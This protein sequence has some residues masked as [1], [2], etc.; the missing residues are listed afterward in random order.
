M[1]GFV[2]GTPCWVDA[3]LPDVAAGKRFYAELF[4]WTFTD[5]GGEPLPGG[6]TRGRRA[7]AYRDGSLVAALTPKRDGRMPTVWSVYL[8]TPDAAALARLITASGGQVINQPFPVGTEGTAAVV[9]DPGGAVFGLWQAGDRAGF[10]TQDEPG[11]YCWA[12]VYT[13]ARERV[14]AFYEGVFGFRGTDLGEGLG[15]EDFRMWSPPGTEPGESTA[16]GGR[17]VIDDS[18]PAEMPGH[19]LVYFR[20]AD[21][22]A[23]AATVLRLGGRVRTEP[24]DIPY[25]RTA[26]LCDDQGATFAVLAEP[27]GGRPGTGAAAREGRETEAPWPHDAPGPVRAPGAAPGG[28]HSETPES[29]PRPVPP[30][31]G[32]AA[33]EETGGGEP[34]RGRLGLRRRIGR[35]RRAR[36]SRAEQR[37]ERGAPGPGESQ[38]EEGGERGAPGPGE[39]QAEEGGEEGAEEARADERAAPREGGGPGEQDGPAESGERSGRGRPGGSGADG[40]EGTGT[41]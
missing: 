28:E 36:G 26:V 29:A 39:S 4:G 11:S 17:S 27:R 20:V 13:R 24:Y 8:A 34:G 1:A 37:G 40:G 31:E 7:D 12:E 22:D 3:S 18:L 9:A 15:P 41:G 2:Q 14:D 38:A 33:A 25:G 19:F 32:G 30:E 35:E 6:G 10:E 23:A 21:C 5:R 16:V